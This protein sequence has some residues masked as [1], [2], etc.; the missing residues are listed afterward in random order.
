MNASRKIIHFEIPRTSKHHIPQCTRCQQY[1]HTQKYCNKPCA[2]VKCDGHHNSAACTKP[3]DT[4]AKWA[5]RGGA[6]PENYKECEYYRTILK[7]NNPRHPFPSHRTPTL[8]QDQTFTPPTVNPPH[9]HQ[10]QQRSYA[11]VARNSVKPEDESI[12]SLKTL[13]DDLKGLFSQLIHQNGMIL[14]MLSTL[15]NKHR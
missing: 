15:F 1:G 4:P 7:G 13:L 11:D 3:H 12:T 14:N 8:I 10:Q 2:C 5:L 6:H 9:P